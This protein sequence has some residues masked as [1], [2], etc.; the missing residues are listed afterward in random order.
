MN[1]RF[2]LLTLICSVVLVHICP[3]QNPGSLALQDLEQYIENA[4]IQWRVPGLTIAIVKDGQTVLEKGFGHVDVADQEL[5][6][7]NTLFVIASTTKAMTAHAMALCVDRGLLDWNDPVTKHLPWFALYDSCATSQTRVIDLFTHNAGVG[8]TDLLWVLWDYSNQEIVR[9]MR[10]RPQAY[11]FRAGYTY[12]NIMY[13][14]AGLVIEAVSGKSWGQFMKEEIWQPLGMTRTYPFKSEA[15]TELNRA[16]PHFPLDDKVIPIIDSNADSIDAAGSVWSCAEDMSKWLKHLLDSKNLISEKQHN[17]L[18]TPK[19]LLQESQFYPTR[20]LTNARLAAYGLGWFFHEY[21]GNLVQFHTGSL[22]G[23]IA[24]VCLVHDENLGIFIAGNLD[25]AELRH[26]LIYRIIDTFKGRENR[27]W[28]TEIK[29]VYDNRY[30]ESK[31][32][33]ATRIP[34]KKPYVAHRHPLAL[35]T[36]AYENYYLGKVNVS[37]VDHRLQ[38]RFRPDRTMT[39]EHYTGE[40][41]SGGIDQYSAW[42][43]DDWVDFIL[44][45]GEVSAIK[46]YGYDFSRILP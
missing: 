42:E 32:N 30:A 16:R 26:A 8:N 31:K 10:Y 22:N 17:I 2:L 41:F 18:N 28:S 19:V 40:K 43:D 7:H 3:G 11:P 36:G 25:H 13:T 33:A 39:L 29:E 6:D 46:I 14:T 34:T 23:A 1:K 24:M 27:D 20:V 9:R 4:R 21:Q 38:I 35:Y 12:Q 37:I 5:V 15:Y 45:D 44:T